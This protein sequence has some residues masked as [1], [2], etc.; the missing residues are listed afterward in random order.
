M[1][2]QLLFEFTVDKGNNEIH[3]KREFAASRKKVWAAWTQ[4]EL[5]D[6]W[7]APKPW[8]AKTKSL[9]FREGG[10]W[11]Y[12]MVGPDGS[13]HWARADYKTINPQNDFTWL[14]G[15]SDENGKLNEALPQ[16]HWSINFE[17]K[18]EETMVAIDIKFETLEDLNQIIEMG[19]KE[20]FTSGL[21]NLDE[22]LAS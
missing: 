10:A 15:F 2:S 3:V 11:I 4:S 19:F 8:K 1:K 13:E 5:L 18:Q 12:S 22:L 21:E 14:D 16:A 20:G 7:W 17:D 9:D 6:Q